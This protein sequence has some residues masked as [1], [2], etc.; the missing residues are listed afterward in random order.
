MHRHAV[1]IGAGITGVLVARAL[2]LRGWRVTVLE[3]EHVGSGSSSRTA[4]GIRQQFSTEA[5]VR[6]MRFAVAA[7]RELPAELG[8]AG[9]ILAPNGYLFLVDRASWPAAR[10]RVAMQRAAGLAEVEALEPDEL[11]RRFPW[12]D[13]TAVAGGTWC[14]T[15]GFLH[16]P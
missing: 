15:D 12:V 10:E 5:T 8:L 14:P 1:V 16:P 7:Y 2:L 6:A 3:A 13:G 11:T 4:A 9:P